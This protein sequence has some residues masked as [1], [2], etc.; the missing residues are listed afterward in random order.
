MTTMPAAELMTA[1]EYMAMP[2]LEGRRTNLVEGK[3]VMDEPTWRHQALV[4]RLAIA[5]VQWLD[6]GDERGAVSIP[7]DVLV[8][9]RNVYSPDVL[10]YSPPRI[11][12][13]PDVRPQA[14]PDLAVE[15]RS[16]ST[17]SYDIGAKKDG[18]E[19]AGVRELW[20]VDT[21]ASEVLVFRRSRP[22]APRFDVSI[23]LATGGVLESPLLEGFA[24]PL[25]ALFA[26]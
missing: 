13:N 22:D 9:D 3:V 10:W 6:A 5:M 12:A 20:L 8:D 7:I 2:E 23:E 25:D 11:P 17:W 1:E 15:I 21:P 4:L 24:L 16:P 19:R 14:V 26:D 18:Y